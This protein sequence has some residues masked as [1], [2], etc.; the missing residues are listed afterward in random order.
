MRKLGG[1]VSPLEAEEGEGEEVTIQ[2][3]FGSVL[4]PRPSSKKKERGI[5]GQSRTE[6]LSLVPPSRG[7]EEEEEEEEVPI[8]WSAV[9]CGF[10]KILIIGS[11]QVTLLCKASTSPQAP[12]NQGSY[13]KETEFKFWLDF[14]LF[15]VE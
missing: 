11:L 14:L 6:I 5:I 10:S 3:K 7:E 12:P 13:L 1:L 8:G 15:K 2:C 4:D 9:I